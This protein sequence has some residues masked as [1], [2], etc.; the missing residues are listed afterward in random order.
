ML[1]LDLGGT[2]DDGSLPF[3]HVKAVLPTIVDVPRLFRPT[4]PAG[5]RC[6]D[7]GVNKPDRRVYELALE[8]LG[9]GA[10]LADCLSITEERATWPPAAT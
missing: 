1:L 3:P 4:P 5:A 6:R 9:T 7:A 2:L 8:H 10:S